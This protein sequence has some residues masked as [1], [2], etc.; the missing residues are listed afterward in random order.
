MSV[1]LTV[2]T[3]L[4]YFKSLNYND[5]IKILYRVKCIYGSKECGAVDETAFSLTRGIGFEPSVWKNP[6]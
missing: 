2:F 4:N 3:Q 5:H 1:T 6:W